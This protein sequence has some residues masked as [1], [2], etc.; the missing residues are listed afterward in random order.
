MSNVP[1]PQDDLF[2]I[3][4]VLSRSSDA[5]DAFTEAKEHDAALAAVARLEER[6]K[7]L[8]SA[9]MFLCNAHRWSYGGPETL[10]ALAEQIVESKRPKKLP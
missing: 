3:R 7:I 4:D 10:I 8:Q 1:G 9:A 6:Y 5:R 2:L